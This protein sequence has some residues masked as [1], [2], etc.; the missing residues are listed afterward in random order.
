MLTV[1][2]FSHLKKNVKCNESKVEGSKLRVYPS[3]FKRAIYHEK[4]THPNRLHTRKTRKR[5][6]TTVPYNKLMG[7]KGEKEDYIFKT[8]KRASD[9]HNLKN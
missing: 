6:L 3:D 9:S 1:W 2:L 7:N 8:N 5:Y 4:K